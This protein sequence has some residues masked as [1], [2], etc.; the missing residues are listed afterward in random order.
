M[1]LHF[2]RPEWLWALLPLALLLVLQSRRQ[3]GQSDWDRYIAPHLAPL[4]LTQ[5]S[6]S[7]RN[8]LPW[9]G[10]AWL[11]AVLALSGPALYKKPLPVFASSTGR[12]LVMDM[13]LSMYATDAAPNR[14]TQARFRATDLLE[15]LNEGETA[16]LAYAGDA[17]VISP[18]TRDRNT[19]LNLLP[20]L[21]PAIMPVRGSN[22]AAALEK[23]KELLS[24]GGHLQGDIILMTDGVGSRQLN[25]AKQA[26][27][28]SH[29]RLAI[30][31]IGSSQ[32]AP[33]RLPDGQLLKDSRNEVVVPATDFG[34]LS[35]LASAGNGILVPYS[36]DGKDLQTLQQWLATSS[37]ATETDLAGDTWVDLGPYLA[38]LLLLPLL[39]SF[40]SGLPVLLLPLS[41][42]LLVSPPSQA[43]GWD[44]LWQT[45]DQ[46]GMQAFK[47]EDFATAADKFVDPA[48]QGSARYRGG[49]YQGALQAFEQDDSA[50]GLYNQG[51]AL[52]QLGQYEEAIKRYS[53]ALKQVP[54][55]QDAIDNKALAESLLKQREQQQDQQS[56]D[57]QED[58]S[59]QDQQQNS[60]SGKDQSQGSQDSAQG[61]NS[62][63]QN[64][65]KEQGQDSQ[66]DQGSSKDSH[67]GSDKD[68]NKENSEPS[69]TDSQ[70]ND[71]DNATEKDAD[72]DA[73][74]DQNPQNAEDNTGAGSE[75]EMQASLPQEQEPQNE[76]ST[77]AGQN[78]AAKRDGSETDADKANSASLAEQQEGPN[79]EQSD[80]QP[81]AQVAASSLEDT[82]PLPPEM[83]RALKA[84]VDDPA[85]LLRNKMQLEYQKRRQRGETP[86]D[87]EQW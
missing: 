43:S 2:I 25:A 6:K 19:L 21:S 14:L 8:R 16:L 34:L 31:A 35:E 61:D 36:N 17:F 33:I 28:G 56:Q 26:I 80:E 76:S 86:K 5:G 15:Q 38:L 40:R 64:Q 46:Q 20:T 82:E 39:L 53:D 84:L 42:G 85:T 75:P 71:A 73:K 57:K 18:L 7:R 32:G 49:D 65:D 78:G 13:S 62:Q 37:D 52:M 81:K 55:M 70:Q 11:V 45:R 48:W 58:Q 44:D 27:E 51:N 4:L 10:L 66:A 63:G 50:T 68:A 30:L 47:Q 9:L 24:Q 12:V 72:K 69:T 1:S 87:N 67:Q 54:D 77:A 29:Y 83:E 22:L 74:G 41:L 59:Q 23:A 3:A 79:D 60:E